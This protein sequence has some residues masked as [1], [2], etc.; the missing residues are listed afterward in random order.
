MPSPTPMQ[1]PT[2]GPGFVNP[3]AAPAPTGGASGPGTDLLPPDAADEGALAHHTDAVEA[4]L[5]DDE[6]NGLH[7]QAAHQL[8]AH[9]ADAGLDHESAIKALH[10]A[11]QALGQPAMARAHKHADLLER[12][13]AAVGT[14]N[15][16]SP[17]IPRAMQVAAKARQKAQACAKGFDAA[18]NSMVS[19]GSAGSSGGPRGAMATPQGQQPAT[20]MPTGQQQGRSGYVNPLQGAGPGY[21]APLG[22]GAPAYDRQAI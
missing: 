6:T 15:P 8:R 19:P 14:V 9:L 10:G 3:L 12:R 16:Q 4:D 21:S 5:A 20:P 18:C 17:H 13:A 11:R 7:P 2:T 1:R 22:P